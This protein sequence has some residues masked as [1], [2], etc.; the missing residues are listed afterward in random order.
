MPETS[1]PEILC[2]MKVENSAKPN[3]SH[4]ND[5]YSSIQ[6]QFL[7]QC[8]GPLLMLSVRRDGTL[9][10]LVVALFNLVSTNPQLAR[11]SSHRALTFKAWSKRGQVPIMLANSLSTM[12]KHTI[13]QDD[14]QQIFKK[15]LHRR[16]FVET[17]TITVSL[18]HAGPK[19]EA[20]GNSLK[21]STIHR[22]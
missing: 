6:F 21:L 5:F 20:E 18:D 7:H 8:L 3:Q 1:A 4:Q 2:N 10:R 12:S 16:A 13:V 14:L 9:N 15:G 19:A 22:P 17:R 11:A